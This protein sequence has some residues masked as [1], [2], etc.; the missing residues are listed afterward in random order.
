MEHSLI[1]EGMTLQIRAFYHSR[2][3][4]ATLVINLIK[5][6]ISSQHI[7]FEGNFFKALVGIGTGLPC[8]VFLANILLH[9]FDLH[10]VSEY[11]DELLFYCRFVDD[12]LA[13]SDRDSAASFSGI[14]SS[15][16][17]C[18]KTEVTQPPGLVVNYLDLI[19][20]LGT[21]HCP[22]SYGGRLV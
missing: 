21:Y 18:I 22:G 9:Q 19:L 7:R 10:I 8:G 11:A 12:C 16:Q 3:G 6:V 4:F 5:V 20:D 2:P 17:P 15:W 13:I 14:A 1:F